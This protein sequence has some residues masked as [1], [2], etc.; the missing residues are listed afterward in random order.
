MASNEYTDY[1]CST[2]T[3]RL[4][5]DVETLL[6]SW[7]VDNDSDRH[8]SIA[9][10]EARSFSI[11]SVPLIRSERLTWALSL[12]LKNRR[13]AVTIELDLSLWDAPSMKG[14]N[15]DLDI[16][17]L[18][19]LPFSLRREPQVKEMPL[20]FFDSFSNL[21]GIGQHITLTPVTTSS[22]PEALMQYLSHSL[23]QRHDEKENFNLIIGSELSSWLQ[24][25]LNC[26]VSNCYCC[27][28]VFGIWG[29]YPSDPKF[30][31]GTGSATVSDGKVEVF[32]PWMQVCREME[33]PSSAIRHRKRRQK[34]HLNKKY[35]PSI[36]A[37]SVVSNRMH[38][39]ESGVCST[40]SCSVLQGKSRNASSDS[41]LTVW[42]KVLLRHCEDDTVVLWGA[43]HAYTWLKPRRQSRSILFSAFASEATDD[44]HDAW[45]RNEILE[46][47]S[48]GKNDIEMYQH[49]CRR[50]ALSLLESSAEAS[51]SD[52][53]WGP[54][55]DPVSSIHAT[56]A[57]NARADE[58]GVVGPLLGFPL[59]IRSSASLS[60]D[61]WID[62][63][64][65]VETAILDPCRSDFFVAQTF[66]DTET[67]VAS[68]A[69]TQR[70]T[71]AAL[72]RT[73]TLPDE[74]LL[75]HITDEDLIE[76]WD[77]KAGNIVAENLASCANV[78]KSTYALVKAMD[79]GTAV[80]DMISLSDATAIIEQVMD[81]SRS[82]NF[83]SPPEHFFSE[84]KQK[85][86][87]AVPLFLKS[88]PVSRLLSLLFVRMARLRSPCSVALVWSLFIDEL[89][90]RWDGL[91]R[92]PNMNYV[93]GIDPPRD[94]LHKGHRLSS[95]C[96]RA[97]FAA[98]LNCLEPDP[99]DYHCL[100]GQKLQI[101]N[102]CVESLTSTDIQSTQDNMH[103]NTESGKNREN[104]SSSDNK[105]CNDA[106][107]GA[108]KNKSSKE[109]TQ[110][111]ALKNAI[112]FSSTDDLSGMEP[113]LNITENLVRKGARCP[114]LGTSL[115][116]SGDEMYAPYLQRP[117]PLTDDV[118]AERWLMLSR[119]ETGTS[120]FRSRL[121]IAFRYQKSKLFSD[122]SAFKAANPG[123]IFRDFISWYGNPGNPLE[124]Y[125][126]SSM[127]SSQSAPGEE[128]AGS[129][130]YNLDKAS[131]AMYILTETRDFWSNTWN[132]ASETPASEQQPVFDAA[133]T[134]EMAIDYL[135]S[136]HPSILLNQIMAV[137]LALVYF[138]LLSSAGEALNVPIV[139]LSLDRLQEKTMEALKLLSKDVT[140][141]TCV[142][143]SKKDDLRSYEGS[144][145]FIS[146]STISSCEIACIALGET[147]ALLARATSL[148]HKFPGDVDLVETIIR[149]ADGEEVAISSTK[150]RE[151]LLSCIQQ[152]QTGSSST[153]GKTA[154]TAKPVLREYMLRNLD[155][156]QPCQLSVRCGDDTSLKEDG[157]EGGVLV[158]LTK[159]FAE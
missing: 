25:A 102:I 89:R 58:D 75:K 16:E 148:L 124:D 140:N 87:K 157:G 33:I 56:V 90:V 62:M 69:A 38:S 53:I 120:S 24:T 72:I 158:A 10:Q 117:F 139:R 22:I 28:P 144:S 7:Y 63:E 3:E 46:V 108:T 6:R 74:A 113:Q 8:V 52:P 110:N 155:D 4:A 105:N 18:E 23:I 119:Q 34:P 82:L 156:S 81:R 100:I 94:V 31:T 20:Y 132:E 111:N 103:H 54:P 106:E 84:T 95:I 138:T 59:K 93:P 26:A 61:D 134:V 118:V 98:F 29:N 76:R 71:L 130:A 109:T 149:R 154:K 39:L 86:D 78:S 40:F 60:R 115:I 125:C 99:D 48:N 51:S 146:V 30:G 68:L 145:S 80:E 79:W 66:Y 37:G 122:M 17:E 12:P 21:F 9:K 92:L 129:V 114:I 43:R 107:P 50:Y 143:A 116:A 126:T 2:A 131:E 152:Q 27:I 127:S 97:D 88:A 133:S 41:G 128:T 121:E 135:E 85:N 5:R 57:W 14:K 147:E 141:S 11:Q 151:N 153:S 150:A 35:I 137:N 136:M 104:T 45:R 64:E 13:T 49:A 70:C 36:L 65:S 67:M 112:N 91:E 15:D 142:T 42:G 55:D 19:H 1:S 73:A 101:F 77:Y 32:P 123:A 159:S 83:P 47:K 96:V 44:L